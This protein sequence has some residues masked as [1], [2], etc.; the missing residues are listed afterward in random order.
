M[1]TQ[2]RKRVCLNI[3]PKKGMKS[4]LPCTMN[5]GRNAGQ[6]LYYSH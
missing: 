3:F 4:Q 6:L 2:K 5:S 1:P